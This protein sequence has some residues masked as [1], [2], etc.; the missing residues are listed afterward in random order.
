MDG[1]REGQIDGWT[2][3]LIDCCTRRW[4]TINHRGHALLIKTHRTLG[5]ELRFLS[6]S[7]TVDL[8]WV[9]IQTPADALNIAGVYG[10][11][12]PLTTP[13][14]VVLCGNCASKFV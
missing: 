5:D 3:R 7:P 6:F 14:L 8:H 11:L 9:D 13:P 2:D 10:A 4:D 12:A 1:G